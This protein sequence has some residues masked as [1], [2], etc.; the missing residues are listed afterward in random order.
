LSPVF[1][2]EVTLTEA[3]VN[4]SNNAVKYSHS[5]S[6]VS[7]KAEEKDDYV[8]ISI[9]DTGVGITE[10]D[11]P[12][13]FDDFF[14]RQSGQAAERGH[15]LGLAISRRIIETHQGSIS[16]ESIPGQGSTFVISLPRYEGNSND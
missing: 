8:V 13:I 16:V 11:L 1:G 4:I 6:E 3:V 14:S 12:L 9:S 15:G 10:D 5:G 7:I 2:D